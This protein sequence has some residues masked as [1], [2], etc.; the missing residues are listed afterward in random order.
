LKK[1]PAF[2]QTGQV[3]RQSSTKPAPGKL[4][5]QAL[6]Q[7]AAE[8]A[9]SNPAQAID[10]LEQ[11]IEGS[12]STKLSA[13]ALLL[14]GSLRLKNKIG[15]KLGREQLEKVISAS[16]KSSEAEKAQM[17]LNTFK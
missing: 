15:E 7:K 11:A 6:L 3:S 5:A 1:E 13:P 9:E 14:S 12:L 2:K 17:V 4:K 10:Y 16:P 8:C